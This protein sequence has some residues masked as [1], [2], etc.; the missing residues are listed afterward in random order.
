LDFAAAND[1]QLGIEKV[2]SSKE[3]VFQIIEK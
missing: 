3:I 2:D 1:V